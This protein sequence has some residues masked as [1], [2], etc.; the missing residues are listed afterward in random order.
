MYTFS[1]LRLPVRRHSAQRQ[2]G[3][4]IYYN[5]VYRWQSGRADMCL[6]N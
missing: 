2:A 4:A 6:Q 1:A 3:K 5:N